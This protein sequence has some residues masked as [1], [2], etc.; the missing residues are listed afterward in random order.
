MRCNPREELEV[1]G[2]LMKASRAGDWSSVADLTDIIRAS[3]VPQL[4]EERQEY[5]RSLREALVV[6]KA[7]RADL[8]MSAARLNAAVGFHSSGSG[9]ATCDDDRQNPGIMADF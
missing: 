8:A 3:T 5:L 1:F 7:S 6:V 9:G 2:L 4:E